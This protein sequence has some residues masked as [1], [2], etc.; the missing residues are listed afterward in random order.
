MRLIPSFSLVSQPVTHCQ[1]AHADFIEI[2]VG[3]KEEVSIKQVA[4]AIVK[5]VGFTGEYSVSFAVTGKGP[6]TEIICSSIL[7]RPMDSTRRLHPMPSS[8]NTS[9]TSNSL[10]SKKVR[11]SI[12][13]IE[14]RTKVEATAL[15]ESVAW[16]VQN[17]DTARTGTPAAV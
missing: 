15:N 9:P 5:A 16:F 17:Y 2:L 1:S 3:E 11:L 10:H 6:K 12:S 7:P 8:S 14:N 13:I 4:D